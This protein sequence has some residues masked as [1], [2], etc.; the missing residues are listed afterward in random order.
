MTYL[1]ILFTSSFC[2]LLDLG[3]L[4]GLSTACFISLMITVFNDRLAE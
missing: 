1:R 2:V 3:M 4:G